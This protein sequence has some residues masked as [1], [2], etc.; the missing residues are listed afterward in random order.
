MLESTELPGGSEASDF[1]F[2]PE[3]KRKFTCTKVAG[4]DDTAVA[5]KNNY[6]RVIK[7][8]Y[9]KG[10]ERGRVAYTFHHVNNLIALIDEEAATMCAVKRFHQRVSLRLSRR[11][12]SLFMWH[13]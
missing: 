7:F 13:T 4:S 5:M 12:L 10:G 3:R 9:I 11:I 8:V 2:V 1:T 6:T